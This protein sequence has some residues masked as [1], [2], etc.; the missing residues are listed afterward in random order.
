MLQSSWE[1]QLA[2]KPAV[3]ITIA[4]FGCCFQRSA[5]LLSLINWPHLLSYSHLCDNRKE[6]QQKPRG[7]N[8]TQSIFPT[9]FFFFITVAYAPT[10]II[11]KHNRCSL[12]LPLPHTATLAHHN[13][14]CT[15][16]SLADR[17]LCAN[18]LSGCERVKIQKIC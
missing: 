7:C 8:G 1:K 9:M 2:M 5:T 15:E 3:V 6:T 14:P 18:Y 10:L 17:D 16:R 13:S 4:N 11:Q 12:W